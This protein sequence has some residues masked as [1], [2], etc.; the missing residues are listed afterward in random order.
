MKLL[1]IIIALSSLSFASD[2]IL[3]T[4]DP[5]W[6]DMQQ[7]F[8]TLTYEISAEI[9][10]D[11]KNNPSSFATL[12]INH[13]SEKYSSEKISNLINKKFENI[14]L[15]AL[16]NTISNIAN[17]ALDNYS[18][19]MLKSFLQDIPEFVIKHVKELDLTNFNAND[20]MHPRYDFETRTTPKKFTEVLSDM[21]NLEKLILGLNH[22]GNF[23]TSSFYGQSKTGSITITK[24]NYN[25]HMHRVEVSASGLLF[26]D[27]KMLCE[28]LAKLPNFKELV[29][30]SNLTAKIFG[31]NIMA[32]LQPILGDKVKITLV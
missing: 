26:D 14:D 28:I 18:S 22:P 23:R 21:V 20:L 5:R 11:I 10:K 24:E 1:S 15:S 2:P 7:S 6:V 8:D 25:Q 12:G 32:D 13:F 17:E 3:N 27:L 19:H 16:N 29:L 30:P 9:R 31:P 4:N